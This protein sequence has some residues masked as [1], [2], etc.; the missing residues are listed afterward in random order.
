MRAR[1]SVV[2]SKSA[3]NKAYRDANREK[4]IQRAKEYY[5][6]NREQILAREREKYRTDPRKYTRVTASNRKRKG[7]VF[8]PG[9]TVES[10]KAEQ[11]GKCAI[12]PNLLEGRNCHVDHCHTTGRVRALLCSGCNLMLGHAK[13]TPERLRAGADYL[14]RHGSN[15]APVLE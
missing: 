3:Y 13:E 6:A 11:G 12:C 2:S 10:M 4:L 14:E 5:Y 8:A 15:P 9:Q 7:M 1:I